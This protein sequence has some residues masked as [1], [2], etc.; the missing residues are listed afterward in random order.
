MQAGIDLNC[1]IGWQRP[2]TNFFKINIDEVV[3]MDQGKARCGGVIRN[4]KGEFL[5]G[6]VVNL[7][8]CSILEVKL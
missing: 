3:K 5:G 7:G 8:C 2:S 4:D 6:F 1:L